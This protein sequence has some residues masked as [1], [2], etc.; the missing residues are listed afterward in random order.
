MSTTTLTP[1]TRRELATR[2]N[3]GLEVTLFW[4]RRDNGTS[5]ELYHAATEQ[6][7]SFRVPPER[8]LDAFHHPFAHLGD[9][10]EHDLQPTD[11]GSWTN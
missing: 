10:P 3:G 6:T 5:I 1:D 2:A 4:D 9:Q 7:I 11:L 8:A